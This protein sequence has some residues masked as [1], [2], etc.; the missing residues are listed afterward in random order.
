M[1]SHRVASPHHVQ[2]LNTG[3][4]VGSSS[5]DKFSAHAAWEDQQESNDL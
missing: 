5:M 2:V 1:V 3:Q 4:G